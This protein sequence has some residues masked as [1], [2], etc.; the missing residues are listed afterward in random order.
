M[1]KP[2]DLGLPQ[3]FGEWRNGQY[4]AFLAA[5]G[6]DKYCMLIDAPTG[7]G[8]SMIGAAIQKLHSKPFIYLV[9]TKQLQDQILKDF[10]YAKTL[11]GRS[12]YPCA[13][14]PKK[15][16]EITAAD[17]SSTKNYPCEVRESCPYVKAKQTAL[18]SE[19]A[20]LNYTYFLSECN[21]AG[22]DAEG[23]FSS[24]G[25]IIADE[26]DMIEDELMS[27][28]S[29]MITAKQLEY[30]GVEPPRFKTKFESWREWAEP[31][32]TRASIEADNIEQSLH[33]DSSWGVLDTVA[34]RRLAAYKK[35]K[36][37]LE[38]FIREVDD[39][40]VWYPGDQQWEF[41]PVWVSKYSTYAI[42]R[43]IPKLYGMSAT[44]LDPKQLDRNIG[45]SSVTGRSYDYISMPSPFNKEN[46]PVYYQPVANVTNKT[47]KEALPVLLRSIDSILDTHKD[48]KVLVHTVSYMISKYIL[49][50]SAHK[51]RMKSHNTFNRSTVLTEFKNSKQPLVLVS[52]SM[53]RG[54]DLPNDECRAVIIAKVPFAYL[55]DPQIAKRLYSS[56]DG[57][58]WYAHRTAGTIIQMAGRGVRA[59][60]DFAST[61]ILDEQFGKLYT[62]N[63]QFF[64]QW[65]REAVIQ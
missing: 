42:W 16:P 18:H 19:L 51:R 15:Y 47:I 2:S 35:L 59:M 45:L 53:D 52:P 34:V 29:L 14:F 4:D 64:P 12:N 57:R 40:W 63:R 46:R 24:F 21:Y 22:G 54:V 62:E 55:G 48:D 10:P 49:D 7:V 37:K 32:R 23:S 5:A 8:K 30:L 36:S 31:A 9:N 1:I 27:H 11:K 41:K 58:A 50:N 60:D 39:T 28:V 65:F 38:F 26:C 56:K 61:Y 20:V 33:K 25:P 17:C 3:K 44:I 43:H 6:C 13:K